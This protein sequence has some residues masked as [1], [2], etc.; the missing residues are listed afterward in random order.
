MFINLTAILCDTPPAVDQADMDIQGLGVGNTTVY[1]CQEGYVVAN[2][3][4][5]TG[6]GTITC[7]L[8][9]NNTAA[10]MWDDIPTCEG[11]FV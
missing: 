1:T 5:T 11:R 6:T 10:A 3:E 4:L 2:I 8:D 9:D 7:V